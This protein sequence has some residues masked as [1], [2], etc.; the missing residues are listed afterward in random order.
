MS[1]MLMCRIR[2]VMYKYKNEGN[3]EKTMLLLKIN[4]E[5]NDV[6]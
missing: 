6:R 3:A 5:I 1:I 2:S 4:E